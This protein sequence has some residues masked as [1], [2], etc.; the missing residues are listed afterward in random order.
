M[1]ANSLYF[2]N[3]TNHIACYWFVYVIFTSF[4]WISQISL[5]KERSPKYLSFV[6]EA[7][8]ML[9]SSIRGLYFVLGVSRDGRCMN[10]VTNVD[11]WQGRSHVRVCTPYD[12]LAAVFFTIEHFLFNSEEHNMLIQLSNWDIKKHWTA[13]LIAAKDKYCLTVYHSSNVEVSRFVI[14]T[15][16]HFHRVLLGP[17]G[18]IAYIC[19]FK[20]E[21]T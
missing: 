13:D 14:S 6:F 4:C 18:L 9:F 8:N 5:T 15:Y 10:W 12:S 7:C 11:I 16:M 1:C 3:I 21:F 20:R 19:C 17:N 2:P